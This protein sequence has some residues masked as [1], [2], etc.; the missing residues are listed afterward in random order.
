MAPNPAVVSLIGFAAALLLGFR[1]NSAYERWY[2]GRKL[3]EFACSR[4]REITRYWRCYFPPKTDKEAAQQLNACRAAVA[5]VYSLMYHLRD[6]NPL[7]H[8]DLVDLIPRTKDGNL[9]LE[10]DSPDA[11]RYYFEPAHR[12][13]QFNGMPS[14]SQQIEGQ[15][16]VSF[17][18]PGT[19]RNPYTYGVPGQLLSML[20]AYNNK[21]GATKFQ[22]GL[23]ESLGNT[24]GALQRILSTP[25]PP[26]YSIHLK[27]TLTVYFL[28]IPFEYL[29]WSWFSIPLMAIA[30]FVMWGFESMGL[31]L[32]NPFGYDANDLPLSEIC[33]ALRREI[34]FT[35]EHPIALP[36][37]WD[38]ALQEVSLEQLDAEIMVENDLS[39][40][41]VKRTLKMMRNQPL[42]SD[43]LKLD[44][45][46]ERMPATSFAVDGMLKGSY[47]V[48]GPTTAT[49]VAANKVVPAVPA[50]PAAVTDAT[51]RGVPRDVRLEAAAAAEATQLVATPAIS[52]HLGTDFPFPTMSTV[53]TAISGM[54]AEPAAPTSPSTPSGNQQPTFVANPPRPSSLNNY[55]RFAMRSLI[56]NAGSE[57]AGAPDEGVDY[58]DMVTGVETK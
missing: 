23:F 50:S 21:I 57:N 55:T 17:R 38:D 6:E 9:A 53:S 49:T 3:F 36:D 42:R 13:V 45:S 28:A 8:E 27:W 39:E 26:I 24:Q 46:L 41:E 4:V 51:I 31:E 5:Y 25:M 1:T 44:M 43:L 32:E 58:W 18:M 47:P 37:D 48:N 22:S 2:E 29:S 15:N 40:E 10:A 34:D 20:L 30:S 56:S 12:V 19:W 14:A 54:P 11:K 16:M 33:A 52:Q 35:V 7:E